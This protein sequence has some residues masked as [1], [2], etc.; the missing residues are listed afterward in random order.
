MGIWE[1]FVLVSPLQTTHIFHGN[2][3]NQDSD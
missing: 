2:S 3:T 1:V